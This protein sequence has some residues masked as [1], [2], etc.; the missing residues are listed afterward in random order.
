MPRSIAVKPKK[1]AT[2]K[3]PGRPSLFSDDLTNRISANLETGVPFRFAC[4]A[5]GVLVTTAE[6]WLAAGKDGDEKH[7]SFFEA[8]TRARARGAIHLHGKVERG[9]PGSHGAQ[10]LLERRYR[11]EYGNV[12]RIE[13]AGHDG[14]TVKVE[15]TTIAQMTDEQLLKL[16]GS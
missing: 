7:V 12:Q 11:D 3:G 16:A 9:G 6:K 4:E 14:G 1:K 5:E 13:H 2:R 15:A 8:V 10:F